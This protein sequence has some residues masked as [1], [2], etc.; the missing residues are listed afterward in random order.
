MLWLFSGGAA[1]SQYPALIDPI[2]G[3]T[4]WLLAWLVWLVMILRLIARVR[5]EIAVQDEPA[6]GETDRPW[7]YSLRTLLLMPLVVW[8]P[9]MRASRS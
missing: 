3:I 1:P 4:F 5:G 2:P 7:Q 9:S 8:L 6:P